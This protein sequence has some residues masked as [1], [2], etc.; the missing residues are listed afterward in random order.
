VP[1]KHKGIMILKVGEAGK[2]AFSISVLGNG[3]WPR[4]KH[5]D[6]MNCLNCLRGAADS[7]NY[8]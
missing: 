4:W 8:P 5:I 7:K 6:P 1:E 2:V 3:G